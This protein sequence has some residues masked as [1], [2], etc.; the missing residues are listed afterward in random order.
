MIFINNL[1]LFINNSDEN[2]ILHYTILITLVNYIY[3]FI[4]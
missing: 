4:L 3:I 2:V 1:M